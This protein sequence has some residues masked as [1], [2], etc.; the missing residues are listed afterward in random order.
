M[1]NSLVPAVNGMGKIFVISAPAGTGKT[2]LVEMLCKEF[3]N[4][5]LCVTTT[6]RLPRNGELDGVQYNFIGKAEF[7]A[8]IEK[9]QFLEYVELFGNFY[10]SKLDTVKK[11][12]NSGRHAVLVIDTQGAMKIKKLLKAV[13][14]F[15]KPPSLEVLEQRL[16]KRGS[17]NQQ[18]KAIRLQRAK[19]ELAF[20]NEYE[21]TIINDK[22]DECY[23]V[24]KSIV[25]AECHKL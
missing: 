5:A 14:I 23:Q 2:T 24:L 6:T 1:S 15:I 12:I 13:F 7:Q 18:E 16:G 21:Y 8:G 11:I 4:I 3:S 10:G 25:I 19:D 20:A 22:L 17:E 9:G